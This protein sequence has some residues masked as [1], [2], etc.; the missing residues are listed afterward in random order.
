MDIW[1]TSS[2]WVNRA[3]MNID[4][5]VFTDTGFILYSFTLPRS[6]KSISLE[7]NNQLQAGEVYLNNQR[8][9]HIGMSKVMLLCHSSLNSKAF[10]QDSLT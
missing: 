4:V 2:S 6:S 7:I 9:L 10:S 1:A 8:D 5:Y 3:S